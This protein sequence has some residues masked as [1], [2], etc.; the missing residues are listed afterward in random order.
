M[1]AAVY[2]RAVSTVAAKLAKYGKDV[3]LSRATVG[4]YDPNTGAASAAT[5]AQAGRAVELSYSARDIDGTNVRRGDRRLLLSPV[6]I[7][8]PLKG[9]NCTVDGVA[10]A[11]VSVEVVRPADVVLY[12][13]VQ[14]RV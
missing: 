1:T 5:S 8:M 10:H 12:Y 4:A 3:A 11:V 13:V 7:S 9:D 2:T 14:L 6:G